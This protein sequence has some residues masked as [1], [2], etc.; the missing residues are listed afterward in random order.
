VVLTGSATITAVF[1]INSFTLTDSSGG[2]GTVSPSGTSSVNYGAATPIIA[3]PNTGY[4]FVKWMRSGPE[5][6]IMD[7]T[8]ASTTVVLTDNATITAVFS[9]NRYSLNIPSGMGVSGFVSPFGLLWV[10]YGAS[11]AI[12]A[13]PYTG[14]HFVKWTRSSLSATISDSTQPSITVVLT[15]NA[16]VTAVFSSD[17]YTLTVSRSGNG[18]VSP[19][20]SDTVKYTD[21][22]AITARADTGYHFV[23]WTRSSL[24]AAIGDSTQP[25]TKVFLT[26][27]ATVTAVFEINTY[28]LTVTNNGSAGGNISPYGSRTVNYGASTA[29][30]ATANTGYHFVEW[31]RDD[32][33]ATI[34][35]STLAS[36]TVV[37]TGSA[38]V[39]AMF[40]YNYYDL[41]MTNI[42]SGTA[43]PSGTTSVRHGTLTLIIATANTGYHFTGWTTSGPEATISS[44]GS[45]MTTLILTG[46]ATIT[47][48]FAINTYTLTV[49]R[50]G[51]GTVSPSGSDTVNY[52]AVTSI[53][54]TPDTGYSFI[55]W[56]R[57]GSAATISDSTQASTGVF[58]TGNA[59][60]AAIF[61]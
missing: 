43:S 20:G 51:N 42:G 52:G 2:N 23:N 4:H 33:T 40:T 58:L 41:T 37:L 9:I 27:S 30:T 12:T 45:S 28:S 19:S 6:S 44:S 14:Y 34:G 7:S 57:S 32:T 21:S 36:T 54:A 1:A 50:S 48:T 16:T 26:G 53:I 61:Q 18:T 3:T 56:T 38:T 8:Q 49:S 13:T 46:P 24:S 11:T 22:T 60:V 15:G 5:A 47:A 55:K 31:I 25:S 17:S 35:D 10:N 29:I 39:T 59:T